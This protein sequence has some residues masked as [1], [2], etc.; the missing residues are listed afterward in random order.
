MRN[1]TAAALAVP[2]LAVLYGPAIARR[3]FSGRAGIGIGTLA[4]SGILVIGLAAPG[5]TSARPPVVVSQLAPGALAGSIEPNH[6]LREP[7]HLSFSEPMDVASVAGALTVDPA[8]PVD[9]SWSDASRGLTISAPAGWKP[10]TYYTISIVVAAHDQTGRPLAAAVHAVFTT[11]ATIVGRLRTVDPP[12]KGAVPTSTLFE[13]VYDGPVDVDAVEAAFRISPAAA[14]AFEAGTTAGGGTLVSYVPDTNLAANTAYTVSLAGSVLDTDGAPTS[15]PAALTVRTAKAPT[16][17][18]FRPFKGTTGVDRYTNLS[19]RFTARMDRRST[20]AA[21]S[22]RVGTTVLKGKVSWAERDTVLV[23]DPGKP[24]PYGKTVVLSVAATAKDRSGT[25]IRAAGTASF[26]VEKHLSQTTSST[27]SSYR[28]T[29]SGGSVGS[30]TWY[31]VELYYLKL[32]NCTR[33]GGWVTSSGY[34][35]SPGG[36]GIAPLTLLSGISN[37]VSRPYAKYLA[38]SGICSHFADGDPGYRL[39][40]AGYYG[41]YRENI[42]CRSGDPYAAVLAT[43][44]FYQSEKPCSG[45]CHYANIMSTKMKYVGIG[46]WVYAGR[47]RLVVDFW[48]G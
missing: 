35:S 48:E 26:K 47:V 9:L 31:S 28:I 7:V 40:R 24:L 12:T 18:R 17:V 27:S 3:I 44:L 2:V 23:F 30:A 14:G 41:D 16:I 5:A 8:T 10:S 21:F 33:T 29:S 22:A 13:V 43:H 20:A 46:V 15:G 19:V 39:R 36:S 42:G 6:G 32:M 1:Y 45:Y 25:V 4:I 34:C 11:R 37:R 38:V